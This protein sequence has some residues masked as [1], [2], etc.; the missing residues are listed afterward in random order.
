[1]ASTLLFNSSPP[2]ELHSSSSSL[3]S[4]ARHY[5]DLNPR[6]YEMLGG[7]EGVQRLASVFYQ[8]VFADDILAPLFAEKKPFHAERLGWLLLS[9]ME[10]DDTYFKKRRGFGTIHAMHQKS[11]ERKE[12]A[13]APRGCGCPGG[14]FTLTQRDAWKGHFLAACAICGLK[15]G[16]M[17]DMSDWVDRSMRFY[18]PFERDREDSHEKKRQ[19]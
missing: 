14:G 19:R 16:L 13:E 9:F 10:V 5:G 7:H 4:V 2:L 3:A 15:D 17:Q 18:G 8:R 11:Q 12:R 6:H 1:M